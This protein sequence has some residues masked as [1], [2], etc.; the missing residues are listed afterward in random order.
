MPTAP[1]APADPGRLRQW[2]ATGR[3]ALAVDGRG[4]SGAFTWQQRDL[5]TTLSIRGPFGAGALRIVADGASITATDGEG[6]R[7]DTEPAKAMLRERLGAELPVTQLRYWMLGLPSPD[8]P[9]EVAEPAGSPSRVIEQSGWRIGYD[10]FRSTAGLALPARFSA[11]LGDIRLKVVV[12]DW[13]VSAGGGP[14]R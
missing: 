3:M 4:G 1:S 11:V 9:A 13:T 8:A 2:T 10:A 5:E 12:D 14:V 6:R 7:I